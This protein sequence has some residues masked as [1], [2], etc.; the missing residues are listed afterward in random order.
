[1]RQ[2][3]ASAA[4][5]AAAPGTSFSV[6]RAYLNYVL[7]VVWFVMLLR[8]V[9]IQIIAAL[10]ESIRQEFNFTDTLLGLLSGA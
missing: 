2:S 7:V 8:F 5:V 6:S 3:E 1:M 10:L 4:A 9:D